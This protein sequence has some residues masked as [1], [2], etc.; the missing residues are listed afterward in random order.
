MEYMEYRAYCQKQ[1][2]REVTLCKF[3]IDGSGEVD[4]DNLPSP[5]DIS[6]LLQALRLYEVHIEFTG[7][8]EDEE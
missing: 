6:A 2:E 8:V 7:R 3:W 4:R 1:E 5:R